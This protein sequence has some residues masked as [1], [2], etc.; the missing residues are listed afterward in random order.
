MKRMLPLLFLLLVAAREPEPGPV[1]PHIQSVLYSP[2]EV[3]LL[4][5]ALGW[6]IMLEFG[7]DERIENVSIGDAL[8]WQVTPNKKARNLFLKPLIKN[9]STN[10]TVVTDKRRYSFSLETAPRLRT[11]PW[12]VRFEYPREIVEV[13]EEPLPPP[14]RPLNFAY[15]LAGDQSLRPSRVW[16]DGL[17]TYFEFPPQNVIPA[18]FAGVPSK[19]ESLV[20]SVIRGRVVIVQQTSGIFTLR[21]GEQ[22]ATVRYG[23]RERK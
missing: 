5:G 16:D 1:D 22:V 4:R 19:S 2:D 6:Q 8:A 13:I 15:T 12:V 9:A 18:I 17:M 10:M 3:V 14:P 7:S 11:T 23:I 21:S 20:N